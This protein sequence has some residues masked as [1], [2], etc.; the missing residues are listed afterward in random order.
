MAD[1]RQDVY[2]YNLERARGH[3]LHNIITC[4]MHEKDLGLQEAIDWLGVWHEEEV[5]GGFR[6]AERELREL[7]QAWPDHV[8]REIEFYINGLG[9]WVRGSDSWHFEGERHFGVQGLAIQK[10][11]QVV[12]LPRLSLSRRA[13]EAEKEADGNVG[14]IRDMLERDSAAGLDIMTKE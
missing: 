7:S 10:T 4:V 14:V 8:A 3:D 2:S 6:K 11:R 12:M 13:N 1:K 5:V 9:C